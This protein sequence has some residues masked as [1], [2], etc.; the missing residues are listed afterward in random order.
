MLSMFGTTYIREFTF[1]NTKHI[2]SKQRNRL[3]TEKTFGYLLRVS[4]SEIKVDFAALSSAIT[5][6]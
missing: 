5:H 3:I 1:S 4:T 2:K 6:P